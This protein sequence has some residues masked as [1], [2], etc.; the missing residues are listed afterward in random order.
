MR[1]GGG[2]RTRQ[3]GVRTRQGRGVRTRQGNEEEKEVKWANKWK[4]KMQKERDN[5]MREND[6]KEK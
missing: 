2:V 1:Q 6:K 5:T 3:G 4:E